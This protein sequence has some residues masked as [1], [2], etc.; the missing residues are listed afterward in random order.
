MQTP[1]ASLQLVPAASQSVKRAQGKPGQLPEVQCPVS[2]L[3][4]A[5]AGQSVNRSQV[6]DVRS[7]KE[8]SGFR[9]RL[10]GARHVPLLQL[11]EASQVPLGPR[12]CL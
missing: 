4:A 12:G 10:E 11:L 6:I 3:H 7:Y 5:P 9:G 2:S 1:R 8:F